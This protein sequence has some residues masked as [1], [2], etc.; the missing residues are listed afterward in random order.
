MLPRR[1]RGRQPP[2]R[3][4]DPPAP[5]P[6]GVAP[7]GPALARGAERHLSTGGPGATAAA[8]PAPA[9]ALGPELRWSHLRSASGTASWARF[10]NPRFPEASTFP[11]APQVNQPLRRSLNTSLTSTPQLQTAAPAPVPSPVKATLTRFRSGS[12][13]PP[14]S[15]VVRAPAFV[16]HLRP[17]IRA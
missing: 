5:G 9:L 16:T 6:L 4:S 13:I 15:H 8:R 10:L 14:E 17:A 7:R 2:P 12:S 11:P 3:D 1:G